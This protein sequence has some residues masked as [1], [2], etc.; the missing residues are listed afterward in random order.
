MASIAV[1]HISDPACPFAYS[2]A[3]FL[4]GLRWRYGD[5][6][7]WRHVMIGLTEE[8]AQYEARGYTPLGSARN[9]R[10]FRRFGMPFGRL[11]KERVAATSPACRVI[12]AV[13]LSDPRLEWPVFRAVQ[14][15]HFTSPV[16]LD[17]ERLLAAAVARVPGLDPDEVLGRIE[18]PEVW[19]AYEADR[20]LARTAE[21]SATELLGKAAR[22]DGPVRY[23][24]PSLLLERDGRVMEGGGFQP[25][26]AYE[27]CVANLDPTL[28]RRPAPEDAGELLAAF[29][30]GLTT[31]EIAEC[32]RQGPF[33][34]D[35]QMAEEALLELAAGGRVVAEPMGDGVL[36]F[37]AGSAFAPDHRR[38][39]ATGTA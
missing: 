7:A 2:A 22:T 32:L 23:T 39:V 33:P 13:R 12:V 29:P 28:Q 30:E 16:A 14:I 24:A 21:G 34:S 19:E 26:E 4:T 36:W 17:D 37:A 38:A 20:G 35:D 6:L 9:Q 25:V 8:A 3:P 18:D 27:V 31:R 1:T 11:P 5:Q 10:R 15:L